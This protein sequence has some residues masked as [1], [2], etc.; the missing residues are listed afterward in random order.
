[1]NNMNRHKRVISLAFAASV[2]ATA[3]ATAATVS[4]LPR[5]TWTVNG[6]NLKV[7]VSHQDIIPAPNGDYRSV[8]L[9]LYEPGAKHPMFSKAL[10]SD[11]T[12]DLPQSGFWPV[13][14]RLDQLPSNAYALVVRFPFCPETPGD[15]D[16]YLLPLNPFAVP[17]QRRDAVAEAEKAEFHLVKIPPMENSRTGSSLVRAQRR[18][19]LTIDGHKVRVQTVPKA[20]DV[21]NVDE[22]VLLTW[23]LGPDGKPI[24]MHN[25]DGRHLKPAA[26]VAKRRGDTLDFSTE[27]T[28]GVYTLVQRFTSEIFVTSHTMPNLPWTH[29]R[30]S[31]PLGCELP[32]MNDDLS[33]SAPEDLTV[34]R[35]S[36][37]TDRRET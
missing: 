13:T 25:S 15:E 23:V 4:A 35:F 16:R 10:C 30:L 37:G 6:N 2:G 22:E 14:F 33:L 8:K 32:R 36:I 21:P 19:T 5:A 34:I 24:T 27:L 12:P 28:E 31:L 29:T 3:I 26:F 1:M 18:T 20:N 17:P 7:E 9:E 11:G